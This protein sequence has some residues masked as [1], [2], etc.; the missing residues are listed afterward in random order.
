LWPRISQARFSC[1]ENIDLSELIEG[2]ILDGASDRYELF[3]R[4]ERPE[5]TSR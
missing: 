4:G 2:H 3:V 5:N 1:P